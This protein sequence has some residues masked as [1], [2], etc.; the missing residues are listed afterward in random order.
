MNPDGF[1][2]TQ[3]GPQFPD[4]PITRPMMV[5]N[6]IC[7]TAPNPPNPAVWIM[8][9]LGNNPH[10]VADN[11]AGSF[12]SPTGDWFA[13]TRGMDQPDGV[14]IWRCNADGS[15]LLR[16]TYPDATHANANASA[17]SPDGKV[18]AFYWGEEAGGT[19]QDFTRPHDVAIMPAF[20]DLPLIVLPSFLT[21]PE[22][23]PNFPPG[24]A[25]VRDNPF[26]YPDGTTLGYD[27]MWPGPNSFGTFALTLGGERQ[28]SPNLRSSPNP[29][30]PYISGCVPVRIV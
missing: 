18:V 24:A 28:L 22:N 23:M 26:W 25:L 30:V 20:G 4:G 8:D 7:F 10:A 6:L 2:K 12:F 19:P 27:K 21:A 3:V 29:P 15:G 14:Q 1:G 11:A 17:I 5:G 16:L 9:A 13:C